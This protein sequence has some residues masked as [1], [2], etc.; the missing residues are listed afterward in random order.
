MKC[1][2]EASYLSKKRLTLHLLKNRYERLSDC[3]IN[4]GINQAFISSIIESIENDEISNEDL[5]YYCYTEVRDYDLN[6]ELSEVCDELQLSYFIVYNNEED[7][8]HILSSDG[9]FRMDFE[10]S[11]IKD[12]ECTGIFRVYANE[13]VDNNNY[14]NF[15]KRISTHIP[16]EGEYDIIIKSL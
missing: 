4:E 16:S 14:E 13:Y 15:Y 3:F 5:N 1:L 9:N 11:Y 7:D 12:N 6:K 8:F 10:G 2:L